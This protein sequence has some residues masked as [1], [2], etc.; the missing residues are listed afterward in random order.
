MSHR[1]RGKSRPDR[2]MASFYISPSNQDDDFG[3][4]IRLRGVC[5]PC[6]FAYRSASKFEPPG[7]D[8]F[9]AAFGIPA[10]ELPKTRKSMITSAYTNLLVRTCC[11]GGLSDSLAVLLP[12]ACGY[13]EIGQRGK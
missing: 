7:V 5:S 2:V 11:E 8:P 10:R 3:S 13:A 1:E 6:A 9:W 4:G 12:C